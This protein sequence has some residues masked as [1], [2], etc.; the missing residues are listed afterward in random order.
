MDQGQRIVGRAL[1]GLPLCDVVA[2]IRRWRP[3]P[4][5]C[6]SLGQAVR[7][8]K[9]ATI[10]LPTTVRI[11]DGLEPSLRAELEGLAAGA[12]DVTS[13]A[14]SETRA[15]AWGRSIVQLE[16]PGD[17][18]SFLGYIDAPINGYGAIETLEFGLRHPEL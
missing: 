7:D 14:D 5:K 9:D 6:Q 11:C 8:P 10:A 1:E 3:A 17:E 13:D 2:V 16:T 4:L 18:S 12:R 15:S